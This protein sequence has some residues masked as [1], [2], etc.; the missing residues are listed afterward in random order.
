MTR[1]I[2]LAISVFICLG[3]SLQAQT[4]LNGE[5]EVK[6]AVISRQDGVVTV[7]MSIDAARLQVK[8]N[9]SVV[10]T[11]VLSTDEMVEKLPSIRVLGRKRYIKYLCDEQPSA[12]GVVVKYNKKGMQPINY[13]AAL[14]YNSWMATARLSI[15]EEE[16]GCSN[17]VLVASNEGTLAVADFMEPFK[18]VLVFAQPRVEATKARS[19]SGSAHLV[20]PVNRMEVRPELKDNARELS[21]IKSTVDLV[22]NDP[23]LTI[24]SIFIK[25]YA[26]PEGAY[27]NNARLAKG[28]T[29]ALQKYVQQIYSFEPSLFSINYEAEN[30]KGLREFVVSGSLNEK[31]GILKIIDS[32][33]APDP[34]EA[35]LKAAYPEAYRFLLAEC[36]PLLRRSDYVINYTVRGFSVEET[37]KL[38]KERP[39]KLSLQEMYLL[40]QTYE[41]GSEP[42]NEVFEIAVRMYPEDE[43]ANLNAANVAIMKNNLTDAGKFLARAGNS[44][45]AVHARGILA[46]LEKDYPTAQRLLKQA[47]EL[48]IQGAEEN[49]KQI[50]NHFK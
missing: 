29:E 5:A 39:Q 15:D 37:A 16:C 9:R 42:Y 32:P 30:W 35:K 26:S 45:E 44:G 28:R 49:L 38:L 14:P 34:K 22:R 3:L 21:K 50:E 41:P 47:A 43:T 17:T 48:G 27:D 36:Y 13:H 11:P 25:G 33:L 7:T 19:E 40:A 10:L 6:N 31:E 24:N 23:D 4:I 2:Y 18:P 1:K 8:P 20:F 12:Q 46:G